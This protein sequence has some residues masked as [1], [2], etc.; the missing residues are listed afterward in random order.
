MSDDPV[1]Y[2]RPLLFTL[3]ELGATGIV[4]ATLG[5]EY[6]CDVTNRRHC[7]NTLAKERR[8]Q[9]SDDPSQMPR[10]TIDAI[11]RPTHRKMQGDR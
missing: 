9:V 5:Y 3:A 8:Y 1:Q 4:A 7:S 10:F 2:S 6:S 11:R